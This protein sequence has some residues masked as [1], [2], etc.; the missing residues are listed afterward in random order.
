VFVNTGSAHKD[1]WIKVVEGSDRDPNEPLRLRK[2]DLNDPVR[3]SRPTGWGSTL[4][5]L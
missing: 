2:G 4:V 1:P 5:E 3:G